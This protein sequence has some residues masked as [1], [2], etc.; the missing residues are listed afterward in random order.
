[1]GWVQAFGAGPAMNAERN[2]PAA[3]QSLTDVLGEH[4]MLLL[5]M[6][7]CCCCAPAAVLQFAEDPNKTQEL[8][9]LAT[10]LTAVTTADN[11]K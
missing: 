5:L 7:L 11:L 9:D 6:L 2:D 8:W 4:A 10:E 3:P 1:M